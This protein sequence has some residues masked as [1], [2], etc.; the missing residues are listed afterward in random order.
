MLQSSRQAGRQAEGQRGREAQ[1]ERERERLGG[2]S[3]H[4]VCMSELRGETERLS[5]QKRNRVN[6]EAAD[7]ERHTP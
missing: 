6:R 3:G 4:G 1:S 7:R 5:E 2:L